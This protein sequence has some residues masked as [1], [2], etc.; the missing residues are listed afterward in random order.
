MLK[1]T[2]DIYEHLQAQQEMLADQTEHLRH[3]QDALA[4]VLKQSKESAESLDWNNLVS[5]IERY[6]MIEKLKGTWES[7]LLGYVGEFELLLT[8]H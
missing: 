5:L 4:N 8:N 1:Q 7:T 6:R 3:V 2:P